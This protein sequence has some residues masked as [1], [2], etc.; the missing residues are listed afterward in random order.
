[1]PDLI[2]PRLARKVPIHF[3]FGP[4][5]FYLYFSCCIR[6]IPRTD[7]ADFECGWMKNGILEKSSNPCIIMYIK[8]RNHKKERLA[9]NN[10]FSRI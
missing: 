10:L 6:H 4:A 2:V 9:G 1:M 7:F 8:M 5:L 3:S